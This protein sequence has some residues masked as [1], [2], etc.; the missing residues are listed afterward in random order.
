MCVCVSV[1]QWLKHVDEQ[2]RPY[3]YSADGSRSEWE[4]P[5]V[6]VVW[7]LSCHSLWMKSVSKSPVSLPP[8]P[9]SPHTHTHTQYNVSPP[10]LSGDISKTRSLDRKHMEPIVLTKWRH[11]AHFQEPTEKVWPP[12]D[13]SDSYHMLVMAHSYCHMFTNTFS[14]TSV[15]LQRLLKSRRVRAASLRLH[16]YRQRVSSPSPDQSPPC[17]VTWPDVI[18]TVLSSSSSLHDPMTWLNLYLIFNFKTET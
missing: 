18:I 16:P 7:V 12:S 6:K 14:C 5:K 13:V 3:Y 8:L 15:T 17:P 11:S 10:Q 2:G 1:P 4:L 9:L